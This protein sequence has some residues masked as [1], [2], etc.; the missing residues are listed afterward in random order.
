MADLYPSR[1]WLSQNT[2]TG[3]ATVS[4]IGINK[5]PTTLLAAETSGYLRLIATARPATPKLRMRHDN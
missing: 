3:V 2:S 4:Y 1:L 5:R